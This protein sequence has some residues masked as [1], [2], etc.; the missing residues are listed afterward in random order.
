MS[1]ESSSPRRGRPPLDPAK[2]KSMTVGIRLTPADF[3]TLHAIASAKGQS[4]GAVLR[5]ALDWILANGNT[6]SN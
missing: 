4:V 3:I 2:R 5:L 1:L 6:H